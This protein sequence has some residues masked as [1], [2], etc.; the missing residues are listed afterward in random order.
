MSPGHGIY[1]SFAFAKQELKGRY[2]RSVIGPFW[3]TI[4]MGVLIASIG[5]VF[6]KIFRTP[7]EVYLP[8]LTVGLILWTFISG[9]I[10]ESCMGFIESEGIIKQLPVPLYVYILR[11]LWRNILILAHNSL[12]YPVVLLVM[13]KSLSLLAIWAIPG[14]LLVLLCLSWVALLFAMLCARYRDLPQ[15]VASIL[16]VAFYF[17]PIV[18]MPLSLPDRVDATFLYFNP[19]YHLLEIIRSPLLGVMPSLTS[20]LVVGVIT[21][22]GWLMALFIFARLRKRVAYWL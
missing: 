18:W 2:R 8:F 7:M 6:G 14:A 11:V 10:T 15:V 22:V 19:F 21:L 5:F 9:T 16:L 3:L 20:W 13:G 17:T 4:S 1:L 12:I